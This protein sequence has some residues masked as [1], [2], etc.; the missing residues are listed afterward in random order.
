[1]QQQG[2]AA[3][4]LL[5]RDLRMAGSRIPK[6]KALAITN[7][8]TGSDQVS[9]L[10]ASPE[11]KFLSGFIITSTG[12]T[13]NSSSI[14]VE[15]QNGGDFAPNNSDYVGKNIIL[16]KRDFSH[17]VIRKIT[18][19]STGTT[20]DERIFTVTSSPASSIFGDS[21]GDI[22]ASYWRQFA[23]I[24]STRT[25]SVSSGVLNINENTGGGSQPLA[26]NVDDLQIAYLDKNGTWYCYDSSHTTAPSTVSDLRA[27]R[28]N[29]V[30][31]SAIADPDYTGRRQAV[32]DHAAGGSDH[33]RRRYFR[34]FVKMR[35]MGLTKEE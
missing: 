17:S 23:Y 24:V 25:Y 33:Y 29:L 10:F 7:S 35:N 13:G 12:T 20:S 21:S 6:S 11:S 9:V 34:S 28:I 26:E 8:S 5:I 18:G 31:R 19:A 2:R 14:T 27:V 30:L 1:M 15:T 16:V 22:S 32:E 3:M 4:N